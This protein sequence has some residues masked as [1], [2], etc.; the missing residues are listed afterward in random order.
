MRLVLFLFAVLSGC[1][2]AAVTPSETDA[3]SLPLLP[4]RT[5]GT[6]LYGS[7]DLDA[8]T[9]DERRVLEDAIRAGLGS[10]SFY[11]DWADLEA[12]PG[13]Y[14]LDEFTDQLDA[15]QALGLVPF[16]NLTVG[17]SG[18]YN[19]PPGLSDGDR[20]IADRVALD[21]PDVTERFGDLLDRV[22]PL[23]V[24]RGGFFLGLG[25]EMGEYLEDDRERRGEYARFVEVAR[26]RV[27]AIEPRLAVGVTLTNGSV[28]TQSATFRAM[29][30]ISDVVAVNH[31]P[32]APDFSVL[33]L[34]DVR[35]DLREV[36]EAYGDGPVVIQEL[37]C[38]SPASMGASEAWQRGCFERLFAEIEAT[39]SVRYASVFTFRDVDQAECQVVRDAL[40][41]D[42]LDDL[43]AD[44]AGRL[45]DYLCFL[46]VVRPGGTPKPAWDAVL[47]ALEPR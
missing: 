34:E 18:G 22:V 17:D 11:V 1:D 42:E 43:P 7:A 41:G 35:S 24:S 9:S 13:R 10:F 25:N 4:D 26:S 8:L 5:L 33:A 6:T 15:L 45:T 12:E 23:L 21:D 37:T 14:T 39:P 47:E 19:L 27:H 16:V 30:A 2:P 28:R 46:G 38:P 44:V 32:I 29:R 20:G 31:S 3:S 40:F 36:T